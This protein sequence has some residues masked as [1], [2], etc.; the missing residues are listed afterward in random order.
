MQT[1]DEITDNPERAAA[2]NR[3]AEMLR[4]RNEKSILRQSPNRRRSR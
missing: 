2:F 3:Y 1:Y 4:E